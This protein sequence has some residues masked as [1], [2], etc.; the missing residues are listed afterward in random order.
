MADDDKLW[1]WL[2]TSELARLALV[3]ASEHLQL[4]GECVERQRLYVTA[5]HTALRAAL[6]GAASAVWLLGP[7]DG[8]ERRQ[9]GLR[10]ASE[11]YRRKAQADEL[12]LEACPPDQRAQLSLQIQYLQD[13]CR[14]SRALWT[15][16]A[17]LTARETP[18]DTQVIHWVALVMFAQDKN[19]QR[20]LRVLWAEMSGDAHALGWQL[21]SRRTAPMTR[22]DIRLHETAVLSEISHLAEPYMGAF[23]LLKRGWSL[24]DQRCSER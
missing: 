22:S 17:T 12:L 13:R 2:P 20:S 14:E 4:V 6:L 5:S 7:T 18:K 23:T 9:R 8:E 19:K 24:F 16:T 3:A 10:S 1:P 15:T 11:W 21:L